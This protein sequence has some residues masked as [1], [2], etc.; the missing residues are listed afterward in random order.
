MNGISKKLSAGGVALGVALGS[1]GIASAATGSTTTSSSATPSTAPTAPSAPQAAP[2][3]WGAQRSDET[4][5]TG[6]TAAKVKEIALAKE[7]GA[8][9]VRV[10]TDADGHATYEAH[11]IESDGTLA[12]VYVDKDLNFVSVESR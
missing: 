2:Q 3:G 6:D 5:L 8:S 7:P 10:E 4:L 11:V 1:Y 12:T 9:V